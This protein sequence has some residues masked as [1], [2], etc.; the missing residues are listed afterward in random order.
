M[1][2]VTMDLERQAEADRAIRATE[3]RTPVRANRAAQDQVLATCLN[4]WCAKFE[5]KHAA[6]LQEVVLLRIQVD[7][8]KLIVAALEERMECSRMAA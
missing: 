1:L 7:E 8:L 4:V 2:Q 3:F 5:E 6:S